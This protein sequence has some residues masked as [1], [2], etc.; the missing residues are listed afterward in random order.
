MEH[1]SLLSLEEWQEWLGSL[2]LPAAELKAAPALLERLYDVTYDLHW[3]DSCLDAQL[4][5]H[6]D[7]LDGKPLSDNPYQG[8]FDDKVWE[9]D[10]KGGYTSLKQ[11]CHE[12]WEQGWHE[13]AEGLHL[14][15][16]FVNSEEAL[17]FGPAWE[18]AGFN[19]EETGVLINLNYT[20]PQ[21]IEE[22]EHWKNAGF[23]R[24]ETIE[25]IEVDCTIDQAL[26]WKDHGCGTGDML[27]SGTLDPEEAFAEEDENPELGL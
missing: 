19:E 24:E 3:R 16:L 9:A 13:G 27:A 23:S 20:L 17:S 12:L 18:R 15:G 22:L 10:G 11:S 8:E 1:R 14:E 2:D 21:A 6:N 25:W 26:G 7:Y 4:I 5:G